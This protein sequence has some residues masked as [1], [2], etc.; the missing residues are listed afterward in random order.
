MAAEYR[1]PRPL[2]RTAILSTWI[3]LGV[4]MLYGAASAFTFA[5][6]AAPPANMRVTIEAAPSDWQPAILLVTFLPSAIS[7]FLILKWIYRT[8]A[9]AQAYSSGMKISPYWNVAFFF[10]PVANLWKPF[11]GLRES[12]E[13][14]TMRNIPSWMRWWWGCWLAAN[15]IFYAS[16]RFGRQAET[17]EAFTVVAFLTTIGAIVSVPLALLLIR[18]IRGL[19]AGQQEMHHDEIFA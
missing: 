11:Q 2:A 4:Q 18:L 7:G 10:I 16:F 6:L 3:W 8:N 5:V 12:W 14:S 17:A 1:D 9:N 15:L 19:T 13:V